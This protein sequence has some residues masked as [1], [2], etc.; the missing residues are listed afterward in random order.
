MSTI[1]KYEEQN[2]SKV[3]IDFCV[4]V[5]SN[6]IHWLSEQKP[7][8]NFHWA[9]GCLTSKVLF[10]IFYFL[11][12]FYHVCVCVCVCVFVYVCVVCEYRAGE[13]PTPTVSTIQE[14]PPITAPVLYETGSV[15]LP[16]ET[17]G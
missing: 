7:Y 15:S 5:F 10:F 17:S 12:F 14:Y 8:Y 16:Q 4:C 6:S 11:Y 2:L 1:W 9:W 13:I 3:C